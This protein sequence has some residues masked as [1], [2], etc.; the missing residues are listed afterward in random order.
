[1]RGAAR[2]RNTSRT[3]F[4]YTRPRLRA[5]CRSPG[6]GWKLAWAEPG[7]R[8][9][10]R[11]HITIGEDT[12]L[13]RGSVVMANGGPVRIGAGSLVASYAIVQAVGGSVEIGSRSSVGDFSNLYGQGHLRIGDNVLMASGVRIMTAEHSFER[14]DVPI[15]QQPERV[16]PTVIGDGAWIAANVI[17][18][19]GVTVGEGAVCAAGAVVTSDVEPYT[20]V[21]GVPARLIRRR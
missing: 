12:R 18:L 11:S 21:A 14:R 16:A 7:V 8:L 5:L 1:M 3:I 2:L 17:I 13:L 4:G 15:A 20:I 19:A 10:R 9:Q 6:G